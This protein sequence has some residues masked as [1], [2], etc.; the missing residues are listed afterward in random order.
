MSFHNRYFLNSIKFNHTNQWKNLWTNCNNK[1]LKEIKRTTLPWPESYVMSGK[2]KVILDHLQIGHTGITHDHNFMSKA[3]P[4][5]CPTCGT[6][7]TVKH[8][9]FECRHSL[10]KYASNRNFW[11]PLM[12]YWHPLPRHPEM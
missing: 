6:L 10:M 9:L 5:F 1:N 2:E 12:K 4:P 3:I 8:V 7:I 11:I